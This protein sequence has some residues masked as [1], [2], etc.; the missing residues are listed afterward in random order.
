MAAA[1][2]PVKKGDDLYFKSVSEYKE[3]ATAICEFANDKFVA[4]AV[5]VPATTAIEKDIQKYN[6]KVNICKEFAYLN[7]FLNDLEYTEDFLISG[8][9]SWTEG[10]LYYQSVAGD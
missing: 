1:G 6:Y 9:P 5:A 4:D 10:S 7:A 2:K 3:L 8:K